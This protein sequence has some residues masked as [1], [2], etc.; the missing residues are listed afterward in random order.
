V[1]TLIWIIE[2]YLLLFGVLLYWLYYA[3]G[4]EEANKKPVTSEIEELICPLPEETN[5]DS[6]E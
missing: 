4:D 3:Q 1:F 2:Y 5:E 6:K